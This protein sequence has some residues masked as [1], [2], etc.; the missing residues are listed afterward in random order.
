M[1]LS[2][3]TFRIL[4]PSIY[5]VIGLLPVAGLIMTIAESP[6]P[7]GF[8]LVASE[9]G[10]RLIDFIDRRLVHLSGLNFWF[11][12]LLAMLLNIGFYFLVGWILDVIVNRYVP[13]VRRGAG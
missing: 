7:F 8:L 12:M 9:P 13:A 5:L 1:K 3:L 4:L 10:F 11:V 6:N 2:R